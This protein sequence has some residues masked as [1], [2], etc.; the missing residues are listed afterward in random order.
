MTIEQMKNA[1]RQRYGMPCFGDV[2]HGHVVV[3]V[4]AGFVMAAPK[5]RAVKFTVQEWNELGMKEEEK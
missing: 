2:K 1:N 5:D 4:G 3:S